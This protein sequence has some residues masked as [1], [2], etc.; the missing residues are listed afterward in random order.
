MSE[1]PWT[2]EMQ[3]PPGEGVVEGL[4]TCLRAYTEQALGLRHERQQWAWVARDEEGKLIGGIT[5]DLVWSWLYVRLLWVNAPWRGRGLGSA[6][7]RAAE[8]RA[9]AEGAI[10]ALVDTADHQAPDFYRKLGYSVF[11]TVPDLPPGRTNYFLQ[12]R[13]DT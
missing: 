3:A 5:A 6:L 12:K 10:G 2:L 1:T 8:E 11:G 13:F 7:L 4:Q 9:V